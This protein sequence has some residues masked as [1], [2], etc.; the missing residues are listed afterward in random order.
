MKIVRNSSES[1]VDKVETIVVA[2]LV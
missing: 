2:L 1:L